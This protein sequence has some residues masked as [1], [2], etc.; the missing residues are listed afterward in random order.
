M[1]R[2]I[3]L[4]LLSLSVPVFAAPASDP[5]TQGMEAFAA[6][7]YDRAAQ[8]FQAA[9]EKRP[10]FAP[11]HYMLA[12]SLLRQGRYV[13]AVTHFEAVLRS[14]A[15]E[16]LRGKAWVNM[17]RALIELKDYD[18][19]ERV[20]RRALEDL[21][22]QAEVFNQLGRARLNRGDYTGAIDVLS[23]ATQLAPNDWSIYNNLGLAYLNAG[24]LKGAL[25]AFERAAQLN[26]RQAFVQ[27]N[28]GVTYERLHRYADAQ[29]AYQRALDIDPGYAKARQS[30]Q[31]VRRLSAS[32][33]QSNYAIGN[34]SS[35]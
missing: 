34:G 35:R 12:M 15:D 14:K 8:R 18:E 27:N 20:A 26:G 13:D 1:Y 11:Y 4:V 17:L 7:R 6:G 21:P 19:V 2:L 5:Y 16:E 10:D 30:I 24:N 32:K 33:Q 29:R 23:R 22:N 25:R 31:R 3:C 9:L 28:L